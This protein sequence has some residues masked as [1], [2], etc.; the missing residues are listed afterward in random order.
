MVLGERVPVVKL[1]EILLPSRAKICG[2][3]KNC[4]LAPKMVCP[5]MFTG[6]DIFGPMNQRKSSSQRRCLFQ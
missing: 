3:F 5:L 4:Y 1:R 2:H 6:I